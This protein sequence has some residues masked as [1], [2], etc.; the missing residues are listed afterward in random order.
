MSSHNWPIQ[1]H[2]Q[3]LETLDERDEAIERAERFEKTLRTILEWDYLNPPQK[4]LCHDLPWLRKLIEEAL[5][6][7]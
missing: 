5:N 1:V 7:Q 2:Q 6:D 3:Y 4:E